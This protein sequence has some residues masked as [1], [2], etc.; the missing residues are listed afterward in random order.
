MTIAQYTQDV[1]NSREPTI[2][3]HLQ[4][5]LH[6]IE[7][8]YVSTVAT[9]TLMDLSKES[10]Y[11]TT[12]AI[13]EL[14]YGPAFQD[15]LTD[16]VVSSLVDMPEDAFNMPGLIYATRLVPILAN[17]VIARL[18]TPKEDPNQGMGKFLGYVHE[19]RTCTVKSAKDKKCSQPFEWHSD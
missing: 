14:T 17:P 13:I 19:V 3:A 6:E 10:Q 1:N 2:D 12:K 8:K 9:T 4:H 15:L 7:E 16:D 11:F 18:L 5:L